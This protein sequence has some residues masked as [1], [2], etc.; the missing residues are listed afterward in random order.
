MESTK[1]STGFFIEP[2]SW[3]ETP[4]EGK[5]WQLNSYLLVL[6]FHFIPNMQLP[7][8]GGVKWQL[9]FGG[10]CFS[11]I[12]AIQIRYPNAYF[13][14]IFIIEGYVYAILVDY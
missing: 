8:L 7:C 11:Q 3:L 1:D 9:H 5:L 10:L 6:E 14:Q 12:L 2:P 13:A 4:L